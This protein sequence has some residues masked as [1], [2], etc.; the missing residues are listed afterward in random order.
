MRGRVYLWTP[1]PCSPFG[2]YVTKAIVHLPNLVCDGVGGERLCGRYVRVHNGGAI[3][4]RDPVTGGLR[5]VRVGDA[6]ANSEGDF[7]FEPGRGGGRIDKVDLAAPDFRWRYVQASHFGEVNTYFHLDRIAAYVDGLLRELGAS[8]LPPVTAIVNAHHAA[9]EIDGVRD[10]VRGTSRWLPFQGAHYRLPARRYDIP[11]ATTLSPDGEIHIGP[12]W[13]LVEHGA[14][15]AVVGGR[16]RAN[17]SHNAGILYH[18]YGHHVTRHTADFSANGLRRLDGQSN[19]K[20]AIDE[21]TSDYWAATMLGTPHIWAL[22][23][24]HDGGTV[25]PRSLVSRKTMA[26]YAL[27]PGADAHTNGTIWA[28]GLCDLREQL[29]DRAPEGARATD[30]LV[31]KSLLLVG[32]RSELQRAPTVGRTRRIRQSFGLALAALVEADELLNRGRHRETIN[33]V[34]AARGIV[35]MPNPWKASS[36]LE[37]TG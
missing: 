30:L 34:S 10:G 23:K 21:G 29:S 2:G 31:L 27:G 9:A 36:D 18:E 13:Q 12:G 24:R 4:E 15:P 16:Y 25:H 28:A 33:A 37:L 17:A 32:T 8:S 3:N 1:D 5:P 7:L 11:E 22:H 35:P 26:D 19:R 14:L 20:T 6:R